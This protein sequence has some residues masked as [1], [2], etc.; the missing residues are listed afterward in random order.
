MYRH[1]SVLAIGFLA[2][3]TIPS[4]GGK[5]DNKAATGKVYMV[6][7][8]RKVQSGMAVDF[9]WKEQGKVVS[10]SELTKGKVVVLNFWGTW[11]GPCRREIPDLIEVQKD[12]AAKGVVVIGIPL[13]QV[14]NKVAVV[15]DFVEKSGIN[16]LNVVDSPDFVLSSAYGGIASVPTTY[17]IDRN[18]KIV[19]K[20]LGMMTKAK[21]IGAVNR[22][23]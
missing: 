10:F 20:I 9:Q 19:E 11:C 17:I 22:A 4:Y 3:I 23:L 7:S 16:Y 12:M 5:D 8:V 21:F 6:E 13:E 2:L 18:G 1:I 14:D 15:K